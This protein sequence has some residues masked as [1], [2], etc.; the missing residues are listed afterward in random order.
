MSS[1]TS[2]GGWEGEGGSPISKCLGCSSYAVLIPV[3]VFRVIKSTAVDFPVP[4]R[5]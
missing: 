2:H 5:V 1:L 3:K 4:Y